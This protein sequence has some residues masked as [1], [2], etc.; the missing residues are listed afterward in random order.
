MG[1]GLSEYPHGFRY[2]KAKGSN[3]KPI[4]SLCLIPLAALATPSADAARP[5]IVFIL[6]DDLGYGDLGIYGSKVNK[7]PTI[8]AMAAEGM[9]FTDF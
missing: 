2:K 1:G 4:L 6:A 3:M 9:R 7:T 5:N 8:D